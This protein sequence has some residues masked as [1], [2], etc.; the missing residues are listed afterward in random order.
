MYIYPK[1]PERTYENRC[2]YCVHF[3]KEGV[4]RD[5]EASEVFSYNVTTSCKILSVSEYS[6]QTQLFD[7]NR[8]AGHTEVLYPDGECRTFAPNLSYPGICQSC[9][10]HNCFVD[11]FCTAKKA[12]DYRRAFITNDHG[13]EQYGSNFYTC[14]NWR[15]KSCWKDLLLQDLSAGKVPAI[16]DPNTFELLKPKE[17]VKKSKPKNKKVE[18]LKFDF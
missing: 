18:L 14:S 6:Y 16:I 5:Y 11:G 1:I 8:L 9:E 7:G 15:M 13:S 12:K 2:K 3:Q 10:Y 4:N 17:Q